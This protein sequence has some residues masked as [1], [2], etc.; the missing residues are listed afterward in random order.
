MTIPLTKLLSLATLLITSHAALADSGIHIEDMWIAEAPP[1]SKVMAAYMEVENESN[2]PVNIVSAKSESFERI[3]FHQTQY[4]ND[5]AKM[6][7]RDKLT[8]PAGGKLKLR[9]GGTHLMLFNPVKKLKA[10]DRVSFVFEL[11]NNKN[12]KTTAEVKRQ[13]L[14]HHETHE[15]HP[16]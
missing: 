9:A 6:Q 1:V 16:H 14:H 15:H 10:G 2:Q 4:E 12:V 8:V 3:E 13:N 7:Q 5:L 11:D